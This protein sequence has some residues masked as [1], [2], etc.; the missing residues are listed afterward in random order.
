MLAPYR[1]WSRHDRERGCLLPGPHRS[2]AAESTWSSGM[3]PVE[4]ERKVDTGRGRRRPGRS[5]WRVHC[6][7]RRLTMARRPG[8]LCCDCR[9][10][11]VRATHGTVAAVHPFRPRASFQRQGPR[12][13]V[14]LP[15]SFKVSRSADSA[16][17]QTWCTLAWNDNLARTCIEHVDHTDQLLSSGRADA[18]ETQRH[19]ARTKGSLCLYH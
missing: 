18:R 17:G 15:A 12:L 4:D 6:G 3:S 8:R 9:T 19:L 5:R 16:T 1:H 13:R 11:A 2:V 7:S 10:P 14:G